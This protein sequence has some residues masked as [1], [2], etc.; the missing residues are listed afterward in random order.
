MTVAAPQR[1][2]L[3]AGRAKPRWDRR[4]WL[5]VTV[6]LV[7]WSMQRAGLDLGA[8]INERGWG[9]VREFFAAMVRPELSRSFVWLTIKEAGTTLAYA[10]LGTALAL[11]IG[12]VFGPILSERFWRPLAGPPSAAARWTW[13][14]LRLGFAA[15][16]AIH[17]VVFGLL[18]VN[19]LGLDPLV[20]VL[21]IGIPF[22]AVTA[23]VFSELIDEVPAGPEL[24]FRAAGARRST[25]LMFGVLPSASA[26]LLSYGFYRLEC[27]IRSA[28]VLGIV[29]VGGLGFQLALSFQSL[30]Y[31]EMWTLLWALIILSGLADR[32]SWAVRHRRANGT[33]DLNALEGITHNPK[34]D[35]FLTGSAAVV[36]LLIPLSWWY[37]DLSLSSL[38]SRRT[39]RLG[40]ELAADVWPPQ[41]GTGGWTGLGGDV[42][43]TIALAV[44]AVAIGGLFASG[45][46]FVAA[47]NPDR[48]RTPRAIVARVAG[49][50]TRFLL[51]TSVG[52]TRSL[53][54]SAWPLAGGHCPWHLPARRFGQAP[55]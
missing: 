39:Q 37:L 5:V 18:L 38:W 7:V 3:A 26:D 9:Q 48:G 1:P 12:V 32:W 27:S 20:A 30:R 19:L 24:A 47:R 52:V 8:L 33:T 4:L 53:H 42:A 22:G 35:P 34:R 28:A 45:L 2:V 21:A 31:N 41:I 54:F 25:A 46:A 14:S 15:P 50:V 36:A 16:R 11:V 6:A 23:K 43:D 29:G 13:R 10:V 17:E 40:R 55:R 49:G 51:L 44:L